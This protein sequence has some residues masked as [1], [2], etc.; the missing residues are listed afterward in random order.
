[1]KFRTL[2]PLAA[3]AMLITAPVFATDAKSPAPKSV[4]AK[5]AKMA[6]VAKAKKAAKK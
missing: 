2:A 6:H 3:V 1:M 4:K 5:P